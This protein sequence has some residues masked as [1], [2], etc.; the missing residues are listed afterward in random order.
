MYKCISKKDS[1]KNLTLNKDYE[2][3]EVG[4]FIEVINDSNVKARYDKKYFETVVPRPRIRRINMIDFINEFIFFNH[5]LVISRDRDNDDEVSI[6]ITY[7]ERNNDFTLFF[8][9]TRNSCGIRFIDGIEQ[10]INLVS[11]IETNLPD[12]VEI[13]EYNKSQFLVELLR[14]VILYFEEIDHSFVFYMFTTHP[15]SRIILSEFDRLFTSTAEELN[16]NSGNDIKVWVASR[17]QL[18]ID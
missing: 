3:T 8:D 4:N 6:N 15:D 17:I 2:G 10:L 18:G 13:S 16:P 12:N 7:R 11:I 9:Q 5:Y 1:F 14:K